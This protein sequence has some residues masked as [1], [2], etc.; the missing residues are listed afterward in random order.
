MAVAAK[1]CGL[2]SPSALKVAIEGGA[3]AV[4]F[5]FYPPSPRAVTAIEARELT[6]LVPDGVEKVGLVVDMDDATL[7]AITAEVELDLLQLHGD[8]TP[9]RVT[10]I[11]EITGLKVM[12]AVRIAEREDVE[13]TDQYLPVAD[14]ILFD[15]RAPKSM[16]GALPGGN[17]LSFDWSWLA[18]RDWD[19]PWMLS[20][21]LD[22]ENV[23]K[24]VAITGA[25]AV[26]V[27]SGVE[28]EPGIKDPRLI[29]SFL[30]AVRNL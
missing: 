10:E 18:G 2:N 3:A 14:R 29:R 4:G 24:A 9:A 17:A 15:A 19:L 27:S 6:E 20:G 7:S 8:E 26:D 1:I 21:G 25:Q 12:K 16:K 23:G 13:L 22:P 11:K 5:V 28:M 30:D